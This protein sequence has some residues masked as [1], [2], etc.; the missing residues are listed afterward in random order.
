MAI[1]RKQANIDVV[2]AANSRVQQV[3][4]TGRE[5]YMSFSGG[6][7]SIVLAD[8]VVNQI[9]L[10]NADPAKLTV[11]FVDE[12][13]I[14]PDVERMVREWRQKFLLL[15]VKFWWLCLQVKHFNCFN[16][17]ANDETFICWDKNKRKDWVRKIPEFAITEHPE[18]KARHETYQSFLTRITS[19]AVQLIGLRTAESVQRLYSVAGLDRDSATNNKMYPIYDWRDNDVWLYLLRNRLDFPI[20]YVY[21][22]QIGTRKNMLRMSQFFSVDTAKSL[23]SMAEFYPDL[24]EKINRREPNAY[25]ATLYWDTEMFR[26]GKKGSDDVYVDGA[27]SDY[28]A[29]AMGMLQDIPANFPGENERTVAGRYKKMIV[30]HWSWITK[31]EWKIIYLALVAGDPKLRKLRSVL[32][33]LGLNRGSNS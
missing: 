12:E 16:S 4:A 17:L 15:G 1:V 27:V 24:L 31:K 18:L 2:E 28:K 14:F 33:D 23:V 7:D 26:K 32:T 30:S 9:R 11:I 3:F 5:V 19:D 10:G 6:K 13:A 21:L 8:V 22:W 25:L 20:E 29:A